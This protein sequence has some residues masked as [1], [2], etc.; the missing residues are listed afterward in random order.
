MNNSIIPKL[1]THRRLVI[2]ATIALAVLA[3]TLSGG[4]V[5]Y[6]RR[7]PQ[8]QQEEDFFYAFGKKIPV[9]VSL[10]TIGILANEGV[11]EGNIRELAQSLELRFLR[12][13]P[14][15]IHI[16]ALTQQATRP[17]IVKLAREVVARGKRI[18]KQAGLVVTPL[19]AEAPMLVSDQ[20]I[21]QLRPDA[22]REDLES[23]NRD[24]SVQIIMQNPFIKTQFLVRVTDN[25]NLDALRLGNIYEE[26]DGPIEFAHADFVKVVIDRETIPTDT[27]FANQW[28]HRNA[29]ASGGTADA[30]TDTSMAWDISQGAAASII[31]VIDSGFDTAHADLTPNFW[32]NPGETAN[33]MDDGDPNPYV[34]DINGWDFGGC[35]IAMPPANCGDNVVTGGNHGTAVAGVAAARGGNSLGVTG[36]CPNCSL[37]L[38]RR[39]STD[40]AQ[41]LAFNYAQQMSAVIVTNSWGFAIGTPCTTNLCTAINNAATLGRGGLGSVVFFAMNNPNVNDCTGA[42][43][44]ISSLANVIGISRSSNTDRF[45]LSGFGNCMDL[46]APS[47]AGGTGTLWVT[48]TDVTGGGGYNNTSTPA[49]CPSAEAAPPPANARDYTSCFNGTSSATPLAAGIAGLLLTTNTGLTRLQVQQL[50]QDTADKIEDSVGRYSANNGFSTPAAGQATHGWGRVN[51]FEAVRVAA[52]VAQGGRAG[53]DLFLRDNRLDWGN[54]EQPSNTLFEPTRG[55]IGHWDSMD[56]KVDA[57]PYETAPTAATFDAFVDQTPSAVAGDVNRVYVRVR[58]RGPVTATTVNVKLHW[59]QFGTALPALPADFWTAFPNNSTN[60][61]QWHPLN[62]NVAAPSPLPATVCQASNLGYSGASVAGT[63]GDVAQVVRFEFPAP[64]VDPMLANHFCLLAMVDSAQDGISSNSR[65]TFVVDSITPTDNNVTHRNYSNLDTAR[66][67]SFRDAFMV[68]NPLDRPIEVVLRARLPR[69]WEFQSAPFALDQPF[70]LEPKQETMVTAMITA[71]GIGETADVVVTQELIDRERKP[72]VMGGLILSFRPNLVPQQP[73]SSDGLV[74]PYLIGTYDLRNNLQTLLHL[75]NPTGKD[76]RLWVA[77]FDDKEKPLRCIK[78]RLTPNDLVE[79]DVRQQKLGASFGVVKVVALN[80]ERDVPEIGVVGN[81]RLLFRA[82]VS[83]TALHQ[84]PE[85]ILKGDMHFI[86]RACAQ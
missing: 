3:V 46:L 47:G 84:V 55:Y 41:G 83:E 49:S 9:T 14:G 18:V 12:S 71:P 65:S 58:N 44:D 34:D 86:K 82:G 11:S 38:I 66:S 29:G 56:I 37:M 69:G 5:S 70:R 76:L 79:I 20:F 75:F 77:F 10:D 54:T 72:S 8:K 48:T 57:P 16:L 17:E 33:A 23:L 42:N 68:R 31:A 64:A 6:S 15:D 73:P 51:A 32:T 67:S 40:F 62:C 27:L 26:K 2:T 7:A 36:S 22:K 4:Y 50:L 52:P 63:A 45:D 24:H 80:R 19:G 30:D 53:V 43:P 1:M 85:D 59:A 78:E 28:H 81:Q 74:T 25:S 21:V 35:D 61:A 13:Y 39:P 60:T